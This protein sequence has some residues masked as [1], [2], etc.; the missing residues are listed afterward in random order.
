MLSKMSAVGEPYY[1]NEK[2]FAW[3]T[4]IATIGIFNYHPSYNIVANL[5][6]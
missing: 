2:S 5:N 1:K 3:F 6:T 4:S